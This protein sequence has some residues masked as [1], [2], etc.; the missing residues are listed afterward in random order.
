MPEP[1]SLP[2]LAWSIIPGLGHLR[3]RQPHLGWSLLC[4]WLTLLLLAL[5]SLG[6]FSHSFFWS[7]VI[8]THAVAFVSLF[9]A[10]LS[11]ERFLI[12]ALFGAM[13]FAA[14][15]FLLYRPI[16]QA[17]SNL[18]ALLPVP[19]IGANEVVT[20]GDV[21]LY[22]GQWLRPTLFGRGDLVAYR[23]NELQE[24]GYYIRAGFNFDRIIGA[25][26]DRVQATGG[27]ILV[28]GDPLDADCQPLADSSLRDFDL[29]V[30]SGHYLILPTCLDVRLPAGG[31]PNRAARQQLLRSICIVRHND[32]LGRIMFRL[33]PLKRFG[34]VR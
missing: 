2:A 18:Y 7:G 13:V 27:V 22:S 34:S 1:V 20:Q 19:Q 29:T 3:I 33:R 9:A 8:V 10:S 17:A 32:V 14:L 23:V 24:S 31:G 5:V 25:P 21:L 11:Y 28:N 30:G 15:H 12:R 6:A 26:G 16:T 4:I